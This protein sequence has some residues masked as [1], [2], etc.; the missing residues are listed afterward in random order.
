M[1]SVVITAYREPVPA[2][3]A[4]DAFLQQL[5]I[6]AEILVVCPDEETTQTV[7]RY[8]AEH[9]QIRHIWDPQAGKPT[10]LNLGKNAARGDILLF[11][12]GDVIVVDQAVERLLHP[13]ADPQV[14]AVSGR[15]R[16]VNPRTTMFGFW[17]HFLTD[18]AHVTRQQRDQHGEFLLCSGYLFAIR[19]VL[20]ADVPADA[21]AE[22]AVISHKIAEQGYQLRYAP[23]AEVLVKY[24]TTYQ[25]WLLQKVRSAGGYI[26][27][28]IQRSPVQ[29]RSF[30]WELRT[31]LNLVLQYP[32][33]V[34]EWLWMALL[35]L[36]RL[37]LWCLIYIKVRWQKQPLPLLWQRVETTK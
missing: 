26:Q 34:Q 31:G 16:S 8:M 23:T 28:Y 33:T 22:D 15:P 12:D 27:P 18:S 17:S 35:L 13:F 10:A 11:S 32:K 9:A 6:D 5:P 29:M 30:W 1:I 3:Y 21:L 24:P 19:R 25:D 20:V 14:G 2:G 4:L 7:K 37:H 36:A